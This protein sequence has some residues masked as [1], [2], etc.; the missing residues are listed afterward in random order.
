[1]C[2]LSYVYTGDYH[3]FPPAPEPGLELAEQIK[4]VDLKSTVQND[5]VL[6]GEGLFSLLFNSTNITKI[7]R[8]LN[9]LD[10]T[11]D[12]P[13]AGGL[14]TRPLTPIED[15]MLPEKPAMFQSATKK[16]GLVED[17]NELLALEILTHSKVYCFAHVYLW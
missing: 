10:T 6:D 8:I 3:P 9:P 13:A 2:F 12:D 14:Y 16:P 7:S 1:L 17:H 15:L 4:T 5:R 11:S